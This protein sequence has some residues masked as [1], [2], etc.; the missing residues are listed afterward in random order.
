MLTVGYSVRGAMLAV[1]QLLGMRE[2]IPGS[3]T[4][5]RLISLC[6]E[7]LAARIDAG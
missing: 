7:S 2:K 4:A 6:R 3:R 1:Y 5:T